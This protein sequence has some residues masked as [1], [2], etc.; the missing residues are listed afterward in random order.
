M[1]IKNFNEEKKLKW[2]GEKTMTNRVNKKF[3]IILLFM[4]LFTMLLPKEVSAATYTTKNSLYGA[5]KNAVGKTV[6]IYRSGHNVDD[7]NFIQDQ[8][9]SHIY[10]VQ[11][12]VTTAEKYYDYKIQNY[13]KIEGNVATNSSGKSVTHNKNLALAYL[14][15]KE[16]WKKGYGGNGDEEVRNLAVKHYMTA[17]GW[18]TSVGIPL[19][20][21]YDNI[22]YFD[23]NKSDKGDSKKQKVRDFI[24]RA[25]EYAKNA[26]KTT[27][28]TIKLA[29]SS[30]KPTTMKQLGPIKF[31]FT[32]SLQ[33]IKLFNGSSEV[34]DSKTYTVG[35][36]TKTIS[37]INSGNN[38]T[39]NKNTE[40]RVTKVE[41]TTKGES[42]IEAEMW[43]CVKSNAKQNLLIT[44]PGTKPNST[45]TSSIN[46]ADV[47]KG[48]LTINKVDKDSGKALSAG[49]KIQTSSGKWLSGK[50]GAY[51]Y[52]NSYANAE[53]YTS[54]ITLNDL[55]LDTYKVYE[56]KAPNNYDITAQTGYDKT[57]KW[58]YCGTATLNAKN[59]KLIKKYQ[60]KKTTG[61]LIINKVDK[62]SGKALS[63]GFKI[64]TSS[65]KWLSG[66]NGAYN[67]DR[68]LANAET[69][70]SPID[71]KELKYG[72]YK[73]FE[74]TPPKNYD[75]ASQEG[76]DKTNRWV[77]FGTATINAK[78]NK[79]E[80]KYTN[81]Q[82]IS[83]KG[84]VWIDLPDAKNQ[85]FNNYF[86]GAEEKA[87]VAGVTVNLRK[88]SN[89]EII[90][91]VK[92]NA[93]GEYIFNKVLS[94]SQLNDY[95]VEFNY[96]GEKTY[97][98][99]QGKVIKEDISKYIPVAFNSTDK[100]QIK[101]NGSRALMEKHEYEDYKET[102]NTGIATT[103]KGKEKETTYGLS[104]NLY[105]KLIEGS[106]LNNINLGIKKIPSADYKVEEKLEYAKISIK[107]FEYKYI[108]G[109]RGDSSKVAAP[110][111]AW[112]DRFINGY[113]A[114]I[115]PS[116]IMYNNQKDKSKELKVE[117]GYRI[118][119]E[120][121][122]ETN[123]EELYKEKTLKITN[124][125]DEFDESR[126]TLIEDENWIKEKGSTAKYKNNIE[127]GPYKTNTSTASIEIKFDVKTEA[128]KN[129]LKKEFRDGIKENKPTTAR[130][131]GHHIYTR[132]DYS[133]EGKTVEKVN[134][135][136]RTETVEYS[137]KAPYLVFKLGQERILSGKVFIDAKDEEK[138]KTT[139]EKL[140]NGQYDD[141]ENLVSGTK[142][143]LLDVDGDE[144]DITRLQPTIIYPDDKDN[145]PKKD[146][147]NNYIG[148]TAE[149]T[150]A[151]NGTYK[152][153]GIVPGYYY[154]RF[155]YGNGAQKIYD[156][157]GKEVKT[158]NAKDYKST[159][160][161]NE[162][163]K[164][165]LQQKETDGLW[166]KNIG[167]ANPSVAVDDLNTRINVNNGNAENII[168]KTAKIAITVENTETN[169]T[170]IEV[171][172]D[173]QTVNSAKNEFDGLSFGII[174]MPEQKA[175]VE[176]IITKMK[177]EDAQNNLICQGN[178][179]TDSLP[180]VSDLDLTTNGGSS[181]VRVEIEAEKIASARLELTYAI[182]ITNTSDVNYYNTDYYFYGIPDPNKEVT[183]VVN[184]L[185]DY[186]D[187]TLSYNKDESVSKFEETNN[188]QDEEL[189]NKTTL[190]LS[191]MD[192]KLYTINNKTRN[193]KNVKTSD[194]ASIVANRPLSDKDEDMEFIN[195]ATITLA[196]NG[197]DADKDDIKEVNI[198][199]PVGDN[200]DLA[201]ATISI[202]P[203]TGAD[204]LLIII[205]TV[206]GTI[207]LAML[208][209]G[210]V[211]IK[212]YVV[213]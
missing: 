169:T 140:G 131:K 185:V 132:R 126:Y 2:K 68:S 112:E 107:G 122:S 117:V 137:S 69:Y 85:L 164:T 94:V 158:I 77:P 81:A 204:R 178:P 53:T 111:V 212:K 129:M 25:N 197:I 110:K 120:N 151:E 36:K 87:R 74:V 167:N 196:K 173:G 18:M 86:D 141:K 124:L 152:F 50:N 23:I 192:T 174:E 170:E 176:K 43:L 193:N 64:Q 51:N 184:E 205:Y 194:T 21:S 113:S 15:E 123:I 207:A 154:L 59:T 44:N 127:L 128:I 139:G 19:G 168:A 89:N 206:A 92:T 189:A 177:L 60:N 181:S 54:P 38:V 114:F 30:L 61:E 163:V 133:W 3:I 116:D 200:F 165:A 88:K 98:N 106:V 172:E 79:V 157:T 83:I 179:E 73:I 34:K 99:E 8:P 29:P 159:I 119:L 14:L 46:V 115:Y 146:A 155:T 76:Y 104:G 135:E 52:N 17:G 20:L 10:C 6:R 33:S 7:N 96:K 105:E 161:T 62:D 5:G 199:K 82:K 71:L 160:I 108:Y 40:N 134:S 1:N 63:A 24:N 41:A 130:A 75:I 109:K 39:I 70:T 102:N 136:H 100:N 201:K 202:M 56:V 144:T 186:L 97:T 28:A 35:G 95:Y 156:P 195:N 55:K 84:Y 148:I 78:A 101:P 42:Y 125:T 45:A 72:T 142:V 191:N 26:N 118:D 65:G 48:S 182:K 138:Y 213:K 145:E 49:F 150:S 58:V 166:Y 147:N 47:V 171:A 188:T 13:I 67:Y 198:Y 103:Y 93:N 90:A 31:T 22:N 4:M 27:V 11:H 91:T 57:N 211:V 121:L 210:V 37:Q 180:G 16:N 190:K 153:R 162:K 187:N 9:S 149:T 32:G 66:K 12:H 203:P 208:S 80:K 209:A 175:K 183:L 143:E